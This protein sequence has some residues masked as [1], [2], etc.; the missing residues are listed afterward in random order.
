MKAFIYFIIVIT[1]PF[2]YTI[3]LW[4]VLAVVCVAFIIL[5]K[6]YKA[7]RI[8]KRHSCFT[9]EERKFVSEVKSIVKENLSNESFS[10]E[11]LSRQAGVS[12]TQ[13]N[14]K[15]HELMDTTPSELVRYYRINEAARLIRDSN[16]RMSE[17]YLMVGFSG[18]APFIDNFKKLYQMTPS[19]YARKHRLDRKTRRSKTAKLNQ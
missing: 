4:C 3:F 12:K 9:E 11:V 14:R 6:K 5:L 19:K 13:L 15:L 8:R 17:I 2:W 7:R 1:F 18:R 10:V 16:K